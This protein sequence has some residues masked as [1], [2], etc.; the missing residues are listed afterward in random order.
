MKTIQIHFLSNKIKITSNCESTN[1]LAQILNTTA[2]EFEN[3]AIDDKTTEK[4]NIEYSI[5]LSKDT[6]SKTIFNTSIDTHPLRLRVKE[7]LKFREIETILQ[8]VKI[9]KEKLT[10]MRGFGSKTIEEINI[11]LKK[12]GLKFEMSDKQISIYCEKNQRA[13]QDCSE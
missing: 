6:L 7:E 10:V 12:R 13:K 9:K 5:L 1:E 2:I 4:Y 8:L 11:F 3:Y